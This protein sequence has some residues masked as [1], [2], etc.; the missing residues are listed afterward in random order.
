MPRRSYLLAGAVFLG[1][2]IVGVELAPSG[3]WFWAALFGLAVGNLFALVMT[4]PLDVA[5]DAPAVAAFT[6]VMLG[7]GYSISATSP[8]VLGAVRDATGSFSDALWLL[9][10]TSAAFLLVAAT[11]SRERLHARVRAS[12]IAA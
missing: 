3:G 2:A 9:V 11:L 1:G 7:A 4:L 5:D 6:G 12:T 10:G 8:F